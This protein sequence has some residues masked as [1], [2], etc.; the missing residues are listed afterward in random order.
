M[1][2]KRYDIDMPMT[3]RLSPELDAKLQE[4]ADARHTSKHSIVLQAVEGFVS[5]Q[6]LSD[7][8]MASVDQTLERDAE[9]L[10]RLEDA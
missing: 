8:I 4:I 5:S 3:I 9:L 6:S 10:R 7:R 2:S 1:V